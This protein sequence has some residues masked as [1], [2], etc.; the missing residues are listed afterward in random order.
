MSAEYDSNCVT[1]FDVRMQRITSLDGVVCS[2]LTV[3]LKRGD[4]LLIWHRPKRSTKRSFDQTLL[5]KRFLFGL[6]RFLFSGFDKQE[7]DHL[8]FQAF[9][10][11]AK[12]LSKIRQPLLRRVS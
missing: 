11:S 6:A 8:N 3:Q 2:R 1:S 12:R 4:C 10:V 5:T 9:K 7:H